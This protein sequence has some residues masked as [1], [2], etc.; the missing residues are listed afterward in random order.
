MLLS[1]TIIAA[2]FFLTHVILMLASFK[3]GVF[4]FRRYF[5]SH[6]TL[7]LAG[8][9]VFCMAALYQDGGGAFLSYFDSGAKRAMILVFTF[10]LSAL[11]HLIVRFLVLPV[12]R[13]KNAMA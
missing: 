7:W 10:G 12:Y 8:L 9:T 1:L 6:L 4:S 2:V 3:G 5:F 11:A 13:R